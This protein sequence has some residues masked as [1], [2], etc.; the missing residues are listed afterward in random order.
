[1]LKLIVGPKGTGK[2]KMLIESVNSAAKSS[3]GNVVCVEKGNMLT[4]SI[5]PSVKLIDIEEY[6]ICGS[7]ELYGFLAG[8]ASDN[9]DVTEIFV[10]GLFKVCERDYSKLG[11]FFDRISGLAKPREDHLAGIHELNFIF[12]VSA[13]RSELPDSLKQYIA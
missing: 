12:T 8:I 9:Y 10:D 3:K 4:F 5:D 13:D 2:T 7:E 6:S 1:M 11:R